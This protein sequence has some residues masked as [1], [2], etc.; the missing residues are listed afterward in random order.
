MGL[1]DTYKE[2]KHEKKHYIPVTDEELND[3]IQIVDNS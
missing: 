1:D 2:L 3:C